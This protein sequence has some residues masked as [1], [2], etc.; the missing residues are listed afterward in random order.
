MH[1]PSRCPVSC[2]DC[3]NDDI[4]C[5]GALVNDVMCAAF[6]HIRLKCAR[7]CA[8]GPIV[9]IPGPIVTPFIPGKVP[10]VNPNPVAPAGPP[11][12]VIA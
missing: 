1:F 4:D 8:A 10:V 3:Y 6:A 2:G 5:H 12:A 9:K 7:T 11:P